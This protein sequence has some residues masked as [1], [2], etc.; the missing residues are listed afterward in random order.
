M[1]ILHTCLAAFYI[2]KYGYQENILPK[3]HKLQ[4][5]NVH[6]LAS[7][8]TYI[9]NNKLG[10]VQPSSYVN[11]NNIPVTRIPYVKWIPHKIVKK[12]RI[13]KGISQILQEFKPDIIFLHDIQ[14]MSIVEIVKYAKDN[15]NVKIYADGHTDFINSARNWIS[16]N[17]LHKIIYRWCAK[18]I[19]PFVKTFWGVIPLRV[20]FFID[21]YGINKDKVDLLVMGV[22]DS[23][24]DI[25]KK[26]VIRKTIRDELNIKKDDFVI[27]TGGK[28]DKR[29]NIDKLMKVVNELNDDKIKLIIFGK[30]SEELEN[31]IN[32][33][34]QSKNIIM[35]GWIEPSKLYD[36]LFASDLAFF[37]GTHSVLWE[38]A[39]GVGLPCVFKRWKGIHHVDVGGNCIFI[40]NG[41]E[42]EIREVLLKIYNNKTIYN[43]LKDIAIEK[44]IPE[45]S[46]F[47][48]AQKAIGELND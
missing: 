23:V 42:D 10:Y 20:D 4:G 41:I 14:F 5:H 30:P 18:Q 36:Y 15:I 28:I 48:I 1:K 32:T 39:V 45:F 31:T 26:E 37:P 2:D 38:Q 12:L 24:I 40:E 13:Y 8:E 9:E 43:N 47:K 19:E 27:V 7:T 46:Y 16:K 17:I 6:I 22:D 44:G 35:I 11:E 29:K 25:S 3:I 34:A 21:V 33:L